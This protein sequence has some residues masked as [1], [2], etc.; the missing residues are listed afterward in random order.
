MDSNV[1]AEYVHII[2]AGPKLEPEDCKHPAVKQY[3]WFAD[4][5]DGKVLC[6]VCLQCNTVLKGA[7]ERDE[8][9]Y[10]YLCPECG[11]KEVYLRKEGDY[12]CGNCGC[13]LEMVRPSDLS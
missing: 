10:R 8:W 3:T 2:H 5:V 11:K 7:E 4:D 1:Q 12:L 6:A 9:D 13:L